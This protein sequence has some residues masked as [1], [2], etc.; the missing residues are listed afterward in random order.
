M[1]IEEITFQSEFS[2]ITTPEQFNIWLLTFWSFN[3]SEMSQQ[4]TTH[5]P[6]LG[7]DY[8]HQDEQAPVDHILPCCYFYIFNH[9][10]EH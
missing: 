5:G 4:K 6:I 8:N 1:Q 9:L 2:N 3:N 10:L 7:T